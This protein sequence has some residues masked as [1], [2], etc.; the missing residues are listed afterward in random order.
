MN[1]IFL[2]FILNNKHRILRNHYSSFDFAKITKT[3]SEINPITEAS[4]CNFA[5]ST[6]I[7]ITNPIPSP[8][9]R[10]ANK[11]FISFIFL[12]PPLLYHRTSNTYFHYR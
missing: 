12:I 6:I 5:P 11:D 2:L 7:G 4:G 3:I 1:I 8:R 9:K 10:Y